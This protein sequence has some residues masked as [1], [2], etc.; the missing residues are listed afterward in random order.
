MVPYGRH[1]VDESDV[2]AVV[3]TLRGGWLTTGPQVEALEA[4]LA[5]WTGGVPCVA[6][7]RARGAS[8]RRRG[9]PGS[10]VAMIEERQAWMAETITSGESETSTFW[11]VV[12]V[13][14]VSGVESMLMIRSGLR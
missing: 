14:T 4:D 10:A 8:L 13:S 2:E 5:G 11:C 1:S 12:R 7:T 6:V 9:E 3:A